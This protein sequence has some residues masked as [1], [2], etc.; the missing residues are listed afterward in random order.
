MTRTSERTT[1]TSEA[2]PDMALILSAGRG[3][4]GTAV[5]QITELLE[6]RIPSLTPHAVQARLLTAPPRPSVRATT[7][8]AGF[9]TD[10]PPTAARI[11]RTGMAASLPRLDCTT[12]AERVR[13]H[14]WLQDAAMIT[15]RLTQSAAWPTP[16][17]SACSS[18]PKSK[19]SPSKAAFFRK[20]QLVTL[21]GTSRSQA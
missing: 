6:L 1:V 3:N 4:R 8:D 15:D 13:V 19:A 7:S 21:S 16:D 11:T 14:S 5:S 12:G 17:R 9:A 2:V 18:Q 10:Q 20:S